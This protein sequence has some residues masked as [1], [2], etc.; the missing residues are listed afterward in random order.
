MQRK[1]FLKNSIGLFS[2]ALVIDACKKADTTTAVTST[3]NTGGTT[4]S[5]VIA[6]TE[7]EG[8]Y[9][10]TGG[11]ITNPLNRSDITGGQTAVPLTITF[12]LLTQAIAVR[13]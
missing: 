10:Y 5:C 9:P 6:P 1:I 4:G 8:P 11:E 2:T 3:T 13:C 7:T 12:T